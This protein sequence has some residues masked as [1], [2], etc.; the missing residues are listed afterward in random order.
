MTVGR[1]SARGAP[2]K[3]A[4]SQIK[5]IA[6]G[7]PEVCCP[8]AVRGCVWVCPVS[9]GANSSQKEQHRAYTTAIHRLARQHTLKMS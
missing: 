4:S 3:N 2:V 8:K 5:G 6:M 7:T 9:E 1:Y